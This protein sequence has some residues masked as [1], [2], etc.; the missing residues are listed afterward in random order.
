MG[1]RIACFNPEVFF[2]VCSPRIIS[3]KHYKGN[4]K[5]RQVKGRIQKKLIVCCVPL[6]DKVYRHS[7]SHTPDGNIMG[8]P[9]FWFAWMLLIDTCCSHKLINEAFLLSEKH[10]GLDGELFGD[11]SNNR[12]YIPHFIG[13]LRPKICATCPNSQSQWLR[14]RFEAILCFSELQLFCQ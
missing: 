4:K 1:L 6:C 7:L 11:H 2:C 5:E 10:H 14:P 9:Y 3:T 13:K 8:W 12:Y